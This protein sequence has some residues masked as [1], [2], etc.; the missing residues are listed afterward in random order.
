MTPSRISRDASGASGRIFHFKGWDLAAARDELDIMWRHHGDIKWIRIFTVINHQKPSIQN[1]INM[2]CLDSTLWFFEESSTW[3]IQR[4]PFPPLWNPGAWTFILSQR[5]F[6]PLWT[7]MENHMI[8]WIE[9]ILHRLIGGLS[10]Y[11]LVV[12]TP[13]KNISQL[14]WLFPIYGK[15]KNVSKPPTSHYL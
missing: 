4:P 9:E 7:K 1:H 5:S 2:L 6:H 12:W 14:G 8:R 11:W 13:L 10:H 3:M 15:I